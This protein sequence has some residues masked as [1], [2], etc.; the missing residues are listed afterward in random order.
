[1]AAADFSCATQSGV[2]YQ[3]CA[4]SQERDEFSRDILAGRRTCNLEFLPLWIRTNSRE[5]PAAA[6]G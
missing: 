5:A 3:K 1:M 6:A 2:T 4:F